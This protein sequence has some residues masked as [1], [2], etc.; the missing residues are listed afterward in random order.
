MSWLNNWIGAAPLYR[1]A[2]LQ[3]N[4]KGQRSKALYARASE[5]PARSESSTSFP[6]QIAS[7]GR[8]LELPAARD[9]ETRLRILTILGMLE[10]NYDSEMARQ[11]WSEVQSLA[12]SQRHY[13]LASRAIGEQGI[14][15]FLL[16]VSSWVNDLCDHLRFQYVL[17]RGCDIIGIENLGSGQIDAAENWWAV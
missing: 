8:D 10:V 4:Q 5:I 15:A 2:E 13:L 9:L 6:S 17:F 11:T 7:L 1:Q 12:I 3:F 14:A 16:G